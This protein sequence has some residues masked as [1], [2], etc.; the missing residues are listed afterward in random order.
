[1]NAISYI[2]R[3]AAAIGRGLSDARLAFR[4]LQRIQYGAPWQ[5]PVPRC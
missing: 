5:R 4:K 3:M 2:T 1:M